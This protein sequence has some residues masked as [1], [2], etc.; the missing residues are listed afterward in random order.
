MISRDLEGQ[1]P[2]ILLKDFTVRGISTL[3]EDERHCFGR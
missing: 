3:C 1:I 2:G